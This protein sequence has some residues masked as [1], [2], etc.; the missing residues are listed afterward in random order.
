LLGRDDLDAVGK[1]DTGD[2]LRQLICSFESAPGFR[3]GADELEHHQFCG[4]ATE[5][6]S[7]VIQNEAT[8]KTIRRAISIG[9]GGRDRTSEWRNQKRK[10]KLSKKYYGTSHVL[11][12]D[13]WRAAMRAP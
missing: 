9:L 13:E 7:S 8:K 5:I 6:L 4:A 11:S 2:D 1:S 10:K 3:G 12:K